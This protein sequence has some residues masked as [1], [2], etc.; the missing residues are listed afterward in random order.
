MYRLESVIGLTE[1]GNEQLD[2]FEYQICQTIQETKQYNFQS[3][4]R[5]LLAISMYLLAKIR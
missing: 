4:D 5:T 3:I 1:S 2:L